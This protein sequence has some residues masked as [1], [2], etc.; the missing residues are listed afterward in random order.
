MRHGS[1]YVPRINAIFIGKLNIAHG[2][3]EAAHFVNF[4]LKRQR[5]RKYRARPLA[6]V[7]AFYLSTLEEALGYFGS[8]LVD[9]SRNQLQ[10]SAILNCENL[11]ATERRLLGVTSAR[12]R[13]MRRF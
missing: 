7:D 11:P 4:A 12:L 6:T 5:Y 8:K 2:A 3:E 10:D 1:C 13:W 9:S